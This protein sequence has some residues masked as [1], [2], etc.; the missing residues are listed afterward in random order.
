MNR[1]YKLCATLSLA[2]MPMLALAEASTP[3]EALTQVLKGYDRFSANFEQ[4]TRSDQSNAAEVSKGSMKVARP[5]QFRWETQSPFPQLIVSDGEYVWIYDPDLEQATRKPVDPKQTNGAALILNGN[6]VEL[7]EKFEI[8]LPINQENEQLF[9]L[10][11]KD[12]QSSF[13]RIRLYFIDGVMSELMLQDVLGQQTTILL[14]DSVINDSMDDALFK[15]TPPKG[16]DVI[17]SDE[18]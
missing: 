10:L 18:A 15:F 5:G 1:L 14:R 4:V 3:T 6:V 8:F 16:T 11:P 13:Q 2:V 17:V 7:A 9:E 12:D